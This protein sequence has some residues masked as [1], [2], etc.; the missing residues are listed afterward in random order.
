M[1]KTSVSVGIQEKGKIS[2]FQLTLLIFTIVIATADVLLPAFVAQEAK[3]D[4]WIAVII[5]TISSLILVNLFLTLGLKYP[6]KTIVEYAVDILGVPLGKLVGFI[7]AY[8]LIFF[9][10]TVVRKLGEIFVTSFNP[11]APIYLFS[12]TIM[13]VAAYSVYGGIEVIARVN[14]V[15]LPIGVIVL[16]LTGIL[17]VAQMDFQRFL[18]ILY[19]GWVPPLKGGLLVQTWLLKSFILLQLIPYVKDEEKKK[20]RKHINIVTVLLGQGLMIGV[21]A[22]AIF[23]PITEKL[24]FS[25]LEYVRFVDLGPFLERFDVLIMLVWIAGIFINI[26]LYYYSA[27][28]G[29]SQLLK[30]KTYRPMVTPVGVIIVSFSIIFA[31]TMADIT[32][33]FHYIYPFYMFTVAAGIPFLLL[34]VSYLK[35]LK[36]KRRIMN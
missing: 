25:A 7:Y 11:D 29:L 8:S 16:L 23:G 3:Q 14:E 28:L 22:I 15:L 33:F 2:V 6:N 20:I 12:I 36:Q 1:E 27:V 35:D 4:S 13:I 5:G 24:L 18:P 34:V 32:H 30:L 21:L 26:V 10:G 17:N 19:D 31:R 9:T